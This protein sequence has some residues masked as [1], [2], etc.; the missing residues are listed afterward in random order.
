MSIVILSY[1]VLNVTK[2]IMVLRHSVL[3][4]QVFGPEVYPLFLAFSDFLNI[5]SLFSVPAMLCPN[6]SIPKMRSHYYIIHFDQSNEYT[7]SYV[8]EIHSHVFIC[9]LHNSFVTIV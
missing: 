1:H 2:M 5:P 4:E 3:L 6:Q 9:T 8:I 7:D